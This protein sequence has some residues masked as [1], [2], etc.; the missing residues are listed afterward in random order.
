M[1][2]LNFPEWQKITND[3]WI[4]NTVNFGYE[5][6]FDNFPCYSGSLNEIPFSE[7]EAKIVSLEVEKLLEKGAVIKVLP[8]KDQFVSSLFLVPKKDGSLRPVINLRKLNEFV[9]YQ[10]FKQEHLSY[11]LDLIQKND[12]LTSIDLTDAYFS[13]SIHQEY[14]KYLRFS[15][16]GV[17]YE[18]K[19]LCFGL[20]SAPR[21]FTK[22]L[23]PVFAFFR[24]QGIRCMYYID[25][26][27]NMNENS[28]SCL[29]NT[30]VMVR[31]LDD[32]GFRV[33]LK[34]SVLVPTKRIVFFGLIIDTVLY[35]VFLTDEKIDKILSFGRILLEKREITIRSL[36]S[37]IGLIVHAFYAVTV[38]RLHYRS[39]ERNKVS[40]LQLACGDYESKIL[41]SKDS[42]NEI[43]WWIE[44]LSLQNG[45]PIRH[46][47]IDC[48]IETDA[49]LLGWG[50]KFDD[51][52]TGGRWNETESSNHIN[53]LELLSI[54]LSLKS[55]FDN[56]NSLHIGIKSDNITAVTYINDMGGMASPL[57]D[58]LS[59][60]IWSWCFERQLFITAQYIP[61]SENFEADHMSRNFSDSTEWKLKEEIFDRICKHFFA[62]DIDL[63]ASRLNNQLSTFASW[64]YDPTASHTD[65]FTF[66]WSN[67]TPY[68][69]P[70]FG[71]INKIIHKIKTDNV[72]K[73]ILVVPFWPTQNW[74]SSLISVLISLPARLPRHTDLLRMP[75]SGELHPLRRKLSLVA[76]TISGRNSLVQEFRRTLPKLSQPLGDQQQLNSTN[77]H[78]ENMFFG[79]V[80]KNIVHFVRLR[81]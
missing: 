53:F 17:L 50:C 31:K 73:A 66:S 34:K 38:G 10:H 67:L 62:P 9:K 71:L 18:F 24:Q 68:I 64:S 15:W 47:P 63:F 40:A 28:D 4:L 8:E 81:L 39:L 27:L 74:F 48:W 52:Y 42:Q 60:D 7:E 36:S 25:D 59:S 78:G 29:E 58:K 77:W 72:E 20:A 70:P 57:L 56:K 6:E 37:F 11:A 80:D 26:S 44:N 21:I 54:F 14:R 13:I 46:K 43:K 23:K 1:R 33:N 51:K 41:L 49:S 12:Y 79:A 55:F 75:H 32:L 35:K 5:I 16:N 30:N 65:A 61:G 69:F 2:K 22:V 45:K 3:Q 76:C 19:V